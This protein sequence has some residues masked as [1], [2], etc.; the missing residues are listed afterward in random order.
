MVLSEQETYQ[1]IRDYPALSVFNTLYVQQE[2]P[3][4]AT[5]LILHGMQEHSGRYQE[6]ARYLANRGFAVLTYDHPGHGKTCQNEVEL[7]F[8][9]KDDPFRL[10]LNVA[11]AMAQKPE[12]LY[13]AVPHFILGH[14]MGSF[15]TRCLLSEQPTR[16][17]GAV[18]IGTGG[19]LPIAGI[20]KALFAIANRYCP[21]RRSLLVNKFFGTMN[22]RKFR[23]D[24]DADDTSWLSVNR[25]NRL[26]FKA[27]KLNGVPFT[28]NGF[29]GLLQFVATATHRHWAEH[30]PKTFPLLFVS[31]ANDPIGDFGKA[32]TKTVH[33]LKREG[34]GN[35]T[36]QLYPGMRHEILN[37]DIRENVYQCIGDWLTKQLAVSTFSEKGV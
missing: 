36:L 2:Q 13:P 33:A 18:I 35:V 4:K 11:S 24:P 8:F 9:G 27:D 10:V 37:E 17:S 20:A 22:N 7:G 6:F 28:H 23:N 5:V 3:I 30:I 19:K 29:Y 26:A 31:G 1:S 21:K 15:I 34:F 25:V 16:F 12:T 32:V 14:S